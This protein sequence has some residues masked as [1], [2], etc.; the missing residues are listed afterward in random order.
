[1]LVLVSFYRTTLCISVVFAV[2]Q[3]LSVRQSVCHVGDCT[4]MAEGIVKLLSR[5]DSH[6]ILVF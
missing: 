3:C 5:P 1:M 6:I 2:G 4:Q